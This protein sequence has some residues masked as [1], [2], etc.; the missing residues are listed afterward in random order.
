VIQSRK[1]P[2]S[3]IRLPEDLWARLDKIAKTHGR[4]RNTEI[5]EALETHALR[6]E[7]KNRK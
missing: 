5:V 7:N 6:E 3:S 4:S 1:A 2:R